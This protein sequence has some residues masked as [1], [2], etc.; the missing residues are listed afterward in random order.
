M[1]IEL[2]TIWHEMNYGAELQAY[3]TVKMLQQL[4]HQVEMINKIGRAHV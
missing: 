3:A 2:L 1:K 4:G